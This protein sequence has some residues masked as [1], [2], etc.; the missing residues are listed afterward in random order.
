MQIWLARECVFFFI[1]Y[2]EK[3]IFIQFIINLGIQTYYTHM[4]A[5][6]CRTNAGVPDVGDE[7]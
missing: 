1:A 2:G 4:Q 7:T 5:P 6:I 3:G